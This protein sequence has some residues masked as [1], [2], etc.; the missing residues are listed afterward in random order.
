[1]ISVLL[2]VR[3]DQ[4]E[5]NATIAS[6][7]ETAGDGPEIIVCD[8]GSEIPLTVDRDVD[9]FRRVDGRCGVGAARHLCA[10]LASRPN[11]LIL[12]SHCRFEPGW[13]EHACQRIKDAP[14]TAWSP[15]CVGLSPDQMDMGKSKKFYCGATINF[16][17]PNKGNPAEM[18]FI[19]PK[20]LGKHPDDGEVIPCLL[21]GAYLLPRDLF[22]RVGGSRLLHSWGSYEPNLSLKIWLSGGECR[23]LR[24]M[25]VGHQF[26]QATTYTSKRAALLFNKLAIATTILPEPAAKFIVDKMTAYHT[27][28]PGDLSLA[29]QMLK[30]EQRHIEVDRAFNEAIFTKDLDWYLEKF[31]LPKF[32]A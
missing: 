15:T 4:V 10:I 6:I 16:C 8:D 1:M 18:Q 7:R 25:R 22:F 11:I 17:G 27:K 30:N 3:N 9:V 12:D 2:P 29:K 21:G 14:N 31:G 32:W 23:L 19:E 13:Y 20:W 26:R 24:S 28:A 5:A